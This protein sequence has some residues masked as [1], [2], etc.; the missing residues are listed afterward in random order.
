MGQTLFFLTEAGSSAADDLAKNPIL[1]SYSQQ[2]ELVALVAGDDVGSHLK[3]RQYLQT[4]YANTDLGANIASI[5]DRVRA[6]LTAR[7]TA[8]EAESSS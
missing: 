3:D 1:G 7:A 6:R 2:V 5:A 8:D 4:T